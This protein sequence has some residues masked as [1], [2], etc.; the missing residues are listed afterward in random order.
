[1]RT[2]KIWVVLLFVIVSCSEESRKCDVPD[3]DF[4]QEMREFVQE[5]STYSKSIDPDFLIIPQN[6]QEILTQD[7]EPDGS[8]AT[9]YIAAIDA[10]GRE[11]L[12]YGYTDDNVATP[13]DDRDFLI[14]F[15]DIAK[16]TGKPVLVTDYCSTHSKMDDSY[17]QNEANGYVSFAADHREL[18][19]IPAYPV[20]IHEE[21]DG[22]INA[23]S[24]VKNFLY[25]IN[26]SAFLTKQAFLDAVKATNYDL[27]LIDLYY[28]EAVLTASDVTSLKTKNNG[29]SRLVICYMSIGEAE[30]YRYY[31]SGLDK[32]LVC[33]ENPDWEGNYA[34]K[35]WEVGWKNV[36]TGN[37]Q[38]YVKKILDAG[39]DGVYMDIIEAYETFE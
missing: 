26:P 30:D 6:G 27:V 22:D 3:L 23:V 2:F 17:T 1:M 9:D 28:N 18:D 11:D 8:L 36:I 35:Y 38:S 19:N 21:S 34:V 32:N 29:A 24:D 7:S 10:V 14:S 37:D 39:F 33:N 25:L 20:T 13:A 31:W 4:R 16:D 12:F 5:I 15:C